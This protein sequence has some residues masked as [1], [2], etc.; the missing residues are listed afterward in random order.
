MQLIHKLQNDR[1]DEY[2]IALFGEI[3]IL[4]LLHPLTEIKVLTDFIS[5]FKWYK[6]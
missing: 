6:K 3:L 2:A 4:L 5:K 1:I